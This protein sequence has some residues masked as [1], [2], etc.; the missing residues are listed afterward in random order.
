MIK[1]LIRLL[2]VLFVSSCTRLGET[3][4]PSPQPT[5]TEVTHT[6]TAIPNTP[7]PTLSAVSTILPTPA[8]KPS[9]TPVVI[10]G[11]NG[12]GALWLHPKGVSDYLV[13]DMRNGTTSKAEFPSNCILR[14]SIKA[15]CKSGEQLSLIDL[16]AS[17]SRP[18]PFKEPDWLGI[19]SDEEF[20]FYGYYDNDES[21]KL[22][23]YSYDLGNNS[24]RL[25]ISQMDG[26]EWVEAFVLSANGEHLAFLGR[27]TQLEHRVFEVSFDDSR[28]RQIGL[29]QPPAT[30]DLAWSPVSAQLVYG[31]TDIQSEI[32]FATNY[33]Y[34]IDLDSNTLHLLAKAPN[35]G[36]YSSFF[37][38]VWSP[39]G[40]QIAIAMRNSSSLCIIRL[41]DNLQNCN[42]V[43]PSTDTINSIAWSPNGDFIA[44]YVNKKGASSSARLILYSLLDSTTTILLTGKEIDHMFWR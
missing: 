11:V 19:S 27:D 41:D 22:T 32:G 39:D 34:L 2:L 4:T 36:V 13:I 16:L 42:E 6:A 9:S 26:A 40:R 1:S 23:I 3:S 25:L 21:K 44:L 43:I 7:S 15:I 38:P 28:I 14:F 17:G 24:E 10:K 37:G 8:P 5:I 33:L 20:L 29:D 30:S 31:A 18:L 12:G 35:G